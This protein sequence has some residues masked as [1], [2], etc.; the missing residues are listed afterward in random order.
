MVQDQLLGNAA[1]HGLAHDVSLGD[2]QLCHEG[3]RVLSEI[4]D[5]ILAIWSRRTTYST[6]VK[7]G[8]AERVTKLGH[9]PGPD[10]GFIR[11]TRDED[12][13]GTVANLLDPEIYPAN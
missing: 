3:D 10:V 11:E 7:R 9:L 1:P 4:N 5:A 8:D 6:V 12:Y 13:V 2:P